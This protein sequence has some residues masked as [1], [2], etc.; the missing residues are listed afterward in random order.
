MQ[1][2]ALITA[3]RALDEPLRALIRA[4]SRGYML[5]DGTDGITQMKEGGHKPMLVTDI[6]G[7]AEL[8][9]LDYLADE[10]LHLSLATCSTGT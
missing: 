6:K 1:G 9:V 10:G 4:N 7:I 8:N 5:V 3:A 2:R